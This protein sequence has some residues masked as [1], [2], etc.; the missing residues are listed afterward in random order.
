LTANKVILFNPRSAKW[1][2]R[3]PNSILQVGASIYGKFDFVFVDG[4]LEEDPWSTIEKYLKTGEYNCFGVTV[5]PGPQ[6]KEAIPFS[7][8]VK[9]KFPDVAVVW[10]G[11]FAANQHRVAL[12]SSYVDVVI[13]GPGDLAFPSLLEVLG[14]ESKYSEIDNIIYI[15]E[16][17]ITKTKKEKLIQ[18][19]KLPQ[20]PYSF[21]NEFYPLDDYLA[22]TFLGERTLAYHSSIGCPFTCSFCAVVPIYNA[23][24]QG[25]SAENMYKDVKWLKENYGLD[26]IEFHDNNFFTSR[27]RVVE[28]SKLILNDN[29]SWWG[30]RQ[31]RH[32]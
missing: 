2:H 14:D 4:N 11:Y 1:K 7:R 29:I 16:F 18:Q 9:K 23:K 13:N 30:R 24:W 5:M 10:G 20:L 12:E 15:G 19:D 31:D 28:F 8:E 6:L 26:S 3:I 22:R 32:R 17:G 21:L 27:K 25:K